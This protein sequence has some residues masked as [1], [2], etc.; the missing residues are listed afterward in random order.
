V[1]TVSCASCHH[2]D[3]GFAKHTQF[4]VGI[5]GQTGGRN[6]PVS[7]N[8]ILSGPQFWDGRAAT[9]EMQAIGPM[10][11][12][13]EMGN[14]HEGVVTKLKSIPG[15]RALFARA[16]LQMPCH[17]RR[18]SSMRRSITRSKPSRSST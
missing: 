8:R 11:N 7:Y 15:Y 10:A 17:G 14:T 9:L 2:P 12:P 4:G 18:L 5:G 6:S 13:I 1:A 16:K 3:E